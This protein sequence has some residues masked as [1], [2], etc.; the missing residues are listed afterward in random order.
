CHHFDAAPLMRAK[1]VLR[2]RREQVPADAGLART[3]I[4]AATIGNLKLN[5]GKLIERLF[6]RRRARAE[7]QKASL[8]ARIPGN[9]A[10]REHQ[11]EA[12]VVLRSVDHPAPDARAD[13]GAVFYD[14]ARSDALDHV[15]R[16]S[17][18][19]Q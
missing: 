6:V 16:I 12:S 7:E 13:H 5:A 17:V 1:T 2:A 11:P 8:M 4:P 3:I 19:Q 15:I 14:P 10:P 18:F 9:V